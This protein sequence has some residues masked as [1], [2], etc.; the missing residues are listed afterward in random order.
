MTSKYVYFCIQNMLPNNLYMGK[1]KFFTS[2]NWTLFSKALQS[3]NSDHINKDL[4]L[5]L[6]SCGYRTV[7]VIFCIINNGSIN[8]D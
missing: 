8:V 7:A 3:Y 2:D 4:T 6:A 5:P 1:N